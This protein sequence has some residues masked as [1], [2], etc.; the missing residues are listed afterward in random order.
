METIKIQELLDQAIE[1]LLDLQ[2]VNGRWIDF[3]IHDYSDQWVSGYAG[4]ALA[5]SLD[6]SL[7]N[8]VA[9][10]NAMDKAYNFLLSARHTCGGW[11]YNA[12]VQPDADSTCVVARFFHQSGYD[13]PKGVVGF[14]KRHGTPAAGY[15]TYLRDDPND[16][17]AMVVPEITAAVSTTLFDLDV[18]S[19]QDLMVSWS[20]CLEWRQRKQGDWSGF[21]WTE[22]GYPTLSVCELLSRCGGH[23]R[24][25]IHYD[26]ID[27][28]QFDMACFLHAATLLGEQDKA[29]DILSHL[30]KSLIDIN[31]EIVI[32]PSAYLQAPANKRSQLSCDEYALD[33]HGVFTLAQIIRSLSAFIKKFPNKEY[34][35]FKLNPEISTLNTHNHNILE[36]IENQDVR[37]NVQSVAHDALSLN[38]DPLRS[39]LA[40]GI[41]LEFSVRLNSSKPSLRF[42]CEIGDIKLRAISRF[43]AQQNQMKEC[44]NFLNIKNIWEKFELV[45][46]NLE[47]GCKYV[48]DPRF[49]SWGG[50]ETALD[51]ADDFK[52]KAYYNAALLDMGLENT[53]QRFKTIFNLLVANDLCKPI[54]N[55]LINKVINPLNKHGF[56][57]EFGIGIRADEKYGFKFYWEFDG[58]N[59]SALQ[60]ILEILH[61]GDV[62]KK[63]KSFSSE[64]VSL[65]SCC[66]VDNLPFGLAIRVD[67]QKGFVDELTVAYKLPDRSIQ[68]SDFYNRLNNFCN[69]RDGNITAYDSFL[70]IYPDN[71]FAPSLI[72]TTVK[73]NKII[74]TLYL[75]PDF[76]SA[77]A[78]YKEKSQ[79]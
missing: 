35:G 26:C 78:M 25:S 65:V 22:N 63:C 20:K 3:T 41:P 55:Y 50:F 15:K 44:A 23:A 47:A 16:R 6:T 9:V 68:A 11:G 48:H 69:H 10:T 53:A 38:R 72:T 77:K 73:E 74:D 58:W 30:A 60:Q 70:K 27:K 75:R 39:V 14:L 67:P 61:L 57:Q 19:E 46:S 52:F 8:C 76:C 45:T 36:N 24:R 62:F 21:W 32:R 51:N 54:D 79:I 5:E 40:D 43:Q 2:H 42:A 37:R 59:D 12:K 33:N 34:V 64:A 71:A 18:L 28:E 13:I 4:L 29:I 49:L 66:E 17:W 56:L 7:Q 1:L 31:R